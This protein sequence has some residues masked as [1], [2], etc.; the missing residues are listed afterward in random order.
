MG[1]CV[2]LSALGSIFCL[3]HGGF[4]VANLPG[5][6]WEQKQWRLKIKEKIVF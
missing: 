3:L 6:Q 1:K 5:K 4:T 2:E